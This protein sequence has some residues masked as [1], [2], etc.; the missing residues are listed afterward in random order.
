MGGNDLAAHNIYMVF[1]ETIR[2]R[3]ICG[4]YHYVCLKVYQADFLYK[5]VD[6][7]VL[8]PFGRVMTRSKTKTITNKE[9]KA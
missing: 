6:S 2:W 4:V 9:T 7:Q 8:I 5:K 3:N 1:L